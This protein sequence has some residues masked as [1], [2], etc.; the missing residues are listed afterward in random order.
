[1]LERCD[2]LVWL[3]L[4]RR[5]VH[6]QV[7]GRTLRRLAKRTELWH[8]NRERVSMLFSRESIVWWSIKT[9]AKRR[10]EYLALF[11]DPTYSD[12]VRVRLR[13]RDEVRRWL[14]ALPGSQP[15]LRFHSDPDS[16]V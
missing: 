2:T 8:G 15:R 6:T 14:D 1:V 5:Q 12:R 10:R 16:Q 13:S 9:F 4:P 7:L 11:E 3:D